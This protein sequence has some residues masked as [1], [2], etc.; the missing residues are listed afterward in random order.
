MSSG[1]DRGRDEEEDQDVSSES[2]RSPSPNQTGS[3]TPILR[4][5]KYFR[6]SEKEESIFEKPVYRNPLK[7][8]AFCVPFQEGNPNPSPHGGRVEETL[9]ST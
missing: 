6:R 3:S 2:S 1:G 9:R 4:S 7:V 8:V 5:R